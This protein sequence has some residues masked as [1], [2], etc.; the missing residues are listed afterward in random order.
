MLEIMYGT[1]EDIVD[2]RENYASF[3]FRANP[4]TG[5][6]EIILIMG[7]GDGLGQVARRAVILKGNDAVE[8]ISFA[9]E[10]NQPPLFRNVAIAARMTPRFSD[11]DSGHWAYHQVMQLVQHGAISGHQDGTF[12]PEESIT[13][14]HFLTM[15]V[16]LAYLPSH[17]PHIGNPVNYATLQDWWAL[18]STENTRDYITRELAFFASY[19]IM[20]AP[21][22]SRIWNRLVNAVPV[23]TENRRF[24]DGHLIEG[25]Y[26]PAVQALTRHHIVNGHVDGNWVRILPKSRITRAEAAALL[27][28]M[29]TPWG[30]LDHAAFRG[31]DALRPLLV[32]ES[33]TIPIGREM[34]VN[35]NSFGAN[36][37]RFTTDERGTYHV[38]ISNNFAAKVFVINRDEQGNETYSPLPAIPEIIGG[39][40]LQISH[41]LPENSTFVVAFSGSARNSFTA[42][43]EFE[44]VAPEVFW[45]VPSHHH[46]NSPFGFR[47]FPGLGGVIRQDIHRGIDVNAPQGTPI[48]AIMAG[49]VVERTVSN[50]G[51][52]NTIVIEHD[53]GFRSR[54]AHLDFV[55]D[56]GIQVEMRQRVEAGQLIG[57]MGNTGDSIGHHL[58][59]ELLNPNGV[60]INPLPVYHPY[61]NRAENGNSNPLFVSVSGEFIVSYV[62]NRTAHFTPVG[63]FVHTPAFREDIASQAQRYTDPRVNSRSL[64]VE[65]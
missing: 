59:F 21:H 42:S 26:E 34:T 7:V 11:I 54:Y 29:I 27:Y 1:F 19:N 12:R 10:I 28:R 60:Q 6:S 44:E 14:E 63:G 30:D 39:N 62:P 56:G 52:G 23:T 57:R 8:G 51:Y 15:L 13:I 9:E 38:I 18:S 3:I 61:S 5:N 41:V 40:W 65:F 37:K 46:T 47:R 58:H 20:S 64:E 25:R 48:H 16:R 49:E 33:L 32:S 22:P 53:N 45:P 36:V 43:I 17:A 31:F 50:L 4:G 24:T 55:A 2:D 35:S